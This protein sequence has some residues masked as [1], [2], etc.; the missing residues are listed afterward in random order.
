[1][2]VALHRPQAGGS[3]MKSSVWTPL[4]SITHFQSYGF[5]GYVHVTP[6]SRGRTGRYVNAW[7]LSTSA[8]VDKRPRTR[9]VG[10]PGIGRRLAIFASMIP[11]INATM[12]FLHVGNIR[13]ST[14]RS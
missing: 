2:A 5:A 8:V 12:S 10:P 13:Q 3:G 14:E 7:R 4:H 6:I 9:A 11:T 1:M